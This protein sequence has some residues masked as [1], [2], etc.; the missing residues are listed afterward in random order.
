MEWEVHAHLMLAEKGLGSSALSDQL[1]EY[2]EGQEWDALAELDVEDDDH[3]AASLGGCFGI[4]ADAPGEALDTAL[5][6]LHR[7]GKAL[8]VPT[9]PFKQAIVS[10]ADVDPRWPVAQRR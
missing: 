2:F 4:V 5:D 7:A 1:M 10:R 6:M 9:G 8:G 3:H